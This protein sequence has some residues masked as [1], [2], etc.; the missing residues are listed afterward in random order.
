[1]KTLKAW[2]VLVALL[3]LGAGVFVGSGAD[4]FAADE[5]HGSATEAVIG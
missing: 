5:P 3:L 2:S 4:N 1:M